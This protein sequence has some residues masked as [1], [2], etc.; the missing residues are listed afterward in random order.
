MNICQRVSWIYDTKQY[1]DEV[2]V[3]LGRWRTRSTPSLPLL[4]GPLSPA[5]VAPDRALSMV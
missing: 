2:P 3:M 4:P 5:M 1:D